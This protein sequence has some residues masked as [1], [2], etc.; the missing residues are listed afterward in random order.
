[1]TSPPRMKILRDDEFDPQQEAISRSYAVGGSVI[2]VV[3]LFAR[4]MPFFS[5]YKPFGLYSM[6]RSSLTPR[7]REL[8]ILRTAV[9]NRSDY[10][11]G[12]HSRIALSAGLTGEE[13]QR[14]KQG[15][16]AGWAAADE[17][18]LRAVDSIRHEANLNDGLY[19]E[20]ARVL[21]EQQ[22]FDLVVTVGNY[23]MV[24]AVLNVA[25]TPLEP[26]LTRLADS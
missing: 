3:R 4:F 18:L 12:H 22:I 17:I 15:P 8:A 14:I 23:N 6:V 7:V 5:A 13:I 9:L 24:S 26:G 19:E 1:M 16:M 2:N 21:D 25:R 20:L 10:E 11:W